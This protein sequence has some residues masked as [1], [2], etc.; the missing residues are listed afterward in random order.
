MIDL[1]ELAAFL[2][3]NG[4]WILIL[5]VGAWKALS[6]KEVDLRLRFKK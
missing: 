5:C 2:K 1:N 6:S 3:D 4:A